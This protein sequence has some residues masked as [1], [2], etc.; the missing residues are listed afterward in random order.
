MANPSNSHAFSQT[1]PTKVGVLGAGQLGRMMALAGLPL[2]LEFSLYDT[3]GAPSAGL[4]QIFSDPENTQQ[5]LDRFLDSVDVVTYEF[6]HLPL[7][8]A[9]NIAS[10]KPLYPGVE[11]LRVCQNREL[12]KGLFRQ[13]NIPTPEYR[14]VSSAEELEK[15]AAELG[16]PVVAK[17]ITEGYDGKG[18]AVLKS[19][20]EAKAAWESIRHPRL[21]VESFV[22][23]SREVSLIAARNTQG[24]FVAYP[25]VENIHH[26]GI[27][28]YTI[29]PAPL[30]SEQT[31]NTASDYIHTL[32]DHLD[33]VGVLALEL[34]ETPEGLLANEMA[35]RVH[36]SGHWSMDGAHTGQFENH[37]RA[38]LGLPLG[39]TA[40]HRVSGMINLISR[41]VD[42]SQILK[43][44]DTHLHL[45]GKDERKGRKV[46][47][48]NVNAESYDE[49][50][51]KIERCLPFVPEHAPFTWNPEL[52]T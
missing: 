19:P 21:I 14:I 11:A 30:V 17:S 3:S 38:I 46:G 41:S 1:R 44:R 35:P 12:E 50:K 28:R 25:L 22:N 34:F 27:L 37:L 18:Q 39:D 24:E 45:Y 23:F 20:S 36:N 7:D 8:L 47:H 31:Q 9:R 43:L 2:G 32:M 10:R 4:G 16:T 42:P 51:D 52:D 26:E 48:I 33:Y 13:L 29:A 6:E 40:P 5:E 15:A 49:L